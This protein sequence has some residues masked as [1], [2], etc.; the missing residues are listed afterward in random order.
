MAPGMSLFSVNAILILSIEDGSR[1]FSKYYSAP[2]HAGSATHNGNSN[3]S[4]NPYPDVKSQKAFEKGLLEKTAKQT[5][6]IILYDNRIVLYKMESD[7]M[8][9]V[10]GGVDEN[11]VLL[12]N[13]ILALRDSLHLLFKQ[14][15]DKRTIV[16]NYDLVSLAI[17]EIVDDGI[18][19]ETDPTIIVQRVSKAPAQDVDLRRIDLSEQGVNNLA[20]LGKSKLADWLRQGL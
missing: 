20:Q 16:E 15:V 3:S 18:I 14:S 2:H 17:D 7:V 5:G 6:D 9:Y 4:G 11:E 13:V 8:M 12:Y 10:V 19:L 1:L